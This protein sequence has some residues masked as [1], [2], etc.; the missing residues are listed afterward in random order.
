MSQTWIIIGGTSTIARAFARQAAARGDGVVLGGDGRAVHARM[1]EA[2]AEQDD[3]RD[4]LDRAR[5]PEG[6]PDEAFRGRDHRQLARAAVERGGPVPDL[7]R[8]GAGRRQ[9]GRPSS[10]RFGCMPRTNP[11]NG[12][13]ML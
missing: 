5:C 9:V 12:G 1:E 10:S 6:M 13:W 11:M 3:A 4:G 7:G 2:P 8:V